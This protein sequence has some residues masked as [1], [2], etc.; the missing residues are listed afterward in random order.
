MTET[1]IKDFHA[2]WLHELG[3]GAV[4]HSELADI[5][6]AHLAEHCN[7]PCSFRGLLYPDGGYRA[8]TVCLKCD[9]AT[10]F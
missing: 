9:T 10:E 2:F 5:E 1:M 3:A 4:P 8:Y 7:R 6:M